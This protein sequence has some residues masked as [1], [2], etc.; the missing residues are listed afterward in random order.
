MKQKAVYSFGVFIIVMAFVQ[1]VFAEVQVTVLCE[2][3]QRPGNPAVGPDGTVY[4]SMHPFDNPEYKIMRLE[5]GHAVPYPDNEVS[6]GLVAVIGIQTTRDG[7]LWWLDM[8]N[9]AVSP[10]LVGWDTRANR[11]KAVHVIPREACVAN[12]F[13]QDFAIDEQRNKAFIA[14]MSRAGMID[15]SQPAIV[16]LDLATGQTRRLLQGH[17]LFQPGGKPLVAEGKIMR[18]T[19]EKGV[20]HEVK[21]GLN[22]IAI[23]PENKWVYF[24]SMSPG[25]LYRVSASILGDF[26]KSEDAIEK[27][28]EMYAQKPSSDGIAVGENGRVYITNVDQSAISIADTSGTRLWTNDSRLIWPDGLYIAPDGSV[29]ATV[30]QLNR[31][32]AFNDGNSRAKKPFLL[33]RFSEK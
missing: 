28:I 4:F 24:A 18:T 33:V 5:K 25:S 26:S 27:V 10:K 16:V 29:V 3:Q 6:K 23:D 20:V 7:I 19:D 14:D 12:S 17:R 31:A 2:L 21:L 9:E 15:E 11:L 32:P 13:L 22:P 8:G 1:T 30:N